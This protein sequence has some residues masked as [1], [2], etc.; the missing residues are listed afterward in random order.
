M[1]RFTAPYDRRRGL[2]A[3]A[4][5]IIFPTCPLRSGAIMERRGVYAVIDS[6]ARRVPPGFAND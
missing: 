4:S 6:P 1:N 5:V 3:L 2:N